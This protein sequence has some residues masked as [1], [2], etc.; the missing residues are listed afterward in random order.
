M[1]RRRGQVESLTSLLDVLFI[2][3]FASLAQASLRD[4]ARADTDAAD[5]GDA[6]EVADAGVADAGPPDAG[7]IDAGVMPL[8]TRARD[9]YLEE[10]GDRPIAIVHV[11]PAGVVRSVRHPGGTVDVDVGLLE[12]VDDPAIRLR[13]LGDA[14]DS[15]TTCAIAAAAIGEERFAGSFAVLAPDAPL[16]TLP[17]ALVQG[18]RRDQ[19]RCL[20]SHGAP[21]V[22]LERFRGGPSMEN[23]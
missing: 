8:A 10:L 23:P 17:V 1:R 7:A 19:R 6:A 13:Y 18:L 11:S 3:V 15:M 5:E 9:A 20:R 4:Q 14:D 2:L 22:L 12:A 16:A 21:T